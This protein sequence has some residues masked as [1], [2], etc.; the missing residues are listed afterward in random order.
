MLIRFIII[1]FACRIKN[2]Y[3]MLGKIEGESMKLTREKLLYLLFL[4]DHKDKKYTITRIAQ[5]MEISKSTVSRVLN[6]FYQEGLLLEKGKGGLS[7]Q[8]CLLAR[9]YKQDINKVAKWL[10]NTVDFNQEEAYQE[11]LSLILTMSKDARNK[12]VNNTS[13]Q[14]L[15]AIIN[16]V[17]EISGDMLGANL[18]DGEYPFAFT[19]YKKDQL[20]ISMANDGFIHPGILKVKFGC[21]ELILTPKEVE[22]ESLMGK[23]VL[24]GK[25]ESL[26]YE[27]DHQ[28]VTSKLCRGRYII[29]ISKLYFFYS[30]EEKILQTTL[31]IKVKLEEG[32]INMP[33]KEAILTIIFK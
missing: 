10:E 31:K 16:N 8:G 30:K 17:K 2:S 20:G 25:L 21:G 9:R 1:I 12:L 14:R 28:Y 18:D 19:I 27:V 5:E 24:K 13:K 32:I 29:P 22:Q 7:C 33:E 26:K 23:I 15:F 6:T 11:A 4:Y 3:Y